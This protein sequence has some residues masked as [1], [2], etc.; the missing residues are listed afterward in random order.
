MALT[1]GFITVSLRRPVL[2]LKR[3]LDDNAFRK[4]GLDAGQRY[5][6]TAPG[7]KSPLHATRVIH[8]CSKIFGRFASDSAL[9]LHRATAPERD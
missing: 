2:Y 9:A 3:L 8:S 5:S 1:V 6:Q 7:T 4:S